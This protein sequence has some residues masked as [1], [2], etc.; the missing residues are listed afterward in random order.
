MNCS[1]EDNTPIQEEIEQT[2]ERVSK[3]LLNLM[4]E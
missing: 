3:I 2:R 1:S 4:I